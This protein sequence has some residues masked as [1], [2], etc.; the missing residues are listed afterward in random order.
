MKIS[1][2]LQDT[3]FDEHEGSQNAAPRIVDALPAV[4]VH[5][6]IQLAVCALLRLETVLVRYLDGKSSAVSDTIAV[7]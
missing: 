2:L 3:R 5:D 6:E 7:E 1:E 4:S